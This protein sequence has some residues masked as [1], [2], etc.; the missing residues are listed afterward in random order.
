MLTG[1]R[2]AA[3]SNEAGIGTAAIAHSAVRTR[4]P[5]TEGLVSLWEPFVDT[6]VICTMTALVIVVTDAVHLNP[7]DNGVALT[8]AAFGTVADWFPTL[9]AVAVFLFAYSTMISYA[10]YGEKAATY[11]FGHSPLVRRGYQALF[12]VCTPIGT[13]MTF[14]RL[15]DFSDAVYFLMALPNVIGM[16]LLAPVVK[17]E[18][19]GFMEKLRSGEIR[20]VRIAPTTPVPSP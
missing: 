7:S 4:Y 2:R 10:Y 15:A 20:N 11:L 8:A 5:V 19:A 17:R 13:A 9:L 16:Y 18:L 1:F 3:F 12:L 6:V 14:T